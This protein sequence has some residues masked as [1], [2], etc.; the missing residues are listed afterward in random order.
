MSF[1]L[2]QFFA[3]VLSMLRPPQYTYYIYVG[4]IIQIFLFY[5]LILGNNIN[6]ILIVGN[7]VEHLTVNIKFSSQ[8]GP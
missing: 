1:F 3:L 2:L 4:F 5:I 8:V 6:L 7:A